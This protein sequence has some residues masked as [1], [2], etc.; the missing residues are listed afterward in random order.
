MGLELHGQ[1]ETH[2]KCRLGGLAK[3][4]RGLGGRIFSILPPPPAALQ[5]KKSLFGQTLD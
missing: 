3:R 5:N 1:S 2:M 4:L